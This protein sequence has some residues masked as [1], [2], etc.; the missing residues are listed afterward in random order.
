MKKNSTLAFLLIFMSSWLYAQSPSIIWQKSFGG[1]NSDIPRSIALTSDNHIIILG[2]TLSK[3]GH[4][5]NNSG[6]VSFWLLDIGTNGV[7]NWE[8]CYGGKGVSE[9]R[10]VNASN[11]GL[12]IAGFVTDTG[13]N[14]SNHYGNQ[15][16]WQAFLDYSGNVQWEKN[17][18]GSLLDRCEVA[19][20]TTDGGYILGGTTVSN[21]KDVIGYLGKQ[22]I[23]VVK[24]DDNGVIEWQKFLGLPPVVNWVYDIIQTADGGYL[25]GGVDSDGFKYVL[26]KLNA[27][28]IILWTK[29]YGGADLD[30]VKRIKQT[31]DGGYIVIGN[32]ESKDGDINHNYGNVDIWILRL[33][34]KG[35][36]LWKKNYGGS[37]KEEGSDIIESV[38]GGFLFVGST[39]SD[40][41]DVRGIH[42]GIFTNSDAWVVKI[43]DTGRIVWQK[44]LGG[45]LDDAAASVLQL[46]D[47]SYVINAASLSSDGDA[48]SNNGKSDFW[49]VRLSHIPLSIS[50]MPEMDQ[51][52]VAPNPANSGINIYNIHPGVLNIRITNIAGQIVYQFRSSNYASNTLT[53]NTENYSTG[54]YLISIAN[55]DIERTIKIQ[56]SR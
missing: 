52:M 14:V 15:D 9:G 43:D 41:H 48:S 1:S 11:S 3:D 25:L 18:G 26:I 10:S 16:F 13:N 49:V 12:H 47:S 31:K 17:Y 8:K 45:T 37:N 6:N 44:C 46:S 55:N 38:E 33:D 51:I 5:S 27:S 50:S 28:G 34:A 19:K 23:W 36:I 4:V 7:L 20:L 35:D 30:Y 39:S 24:T 54:M 42:K 56:I 32:I 2:T 40:D 29:K 53:I 22:G 21:D